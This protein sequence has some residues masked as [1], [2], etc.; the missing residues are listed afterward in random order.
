[1]NKIPIHTSTTK[2]ELDELSKKFNEQIKEE[3]QQLQGN[4]SSIHPPGT[5]K[6]ITKLLHPPPRSTAFI[7]DIR[8]PWLRI[9]LCF[10]V[11]PVAITACGL[12]G[13]FCGAR[14]AVEALVEAIEGES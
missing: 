7:A 5:Q 13:F 3:W 11:A 1:M 9:P 10:L 2:A 12:V 4:F 6:A 14:E 8:N